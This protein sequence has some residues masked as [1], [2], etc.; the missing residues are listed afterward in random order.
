MLML[1]RH[2]LFLNLC[3][4]LIS[5]FTSIEAFAT[6]EVTQVPT[7]IGNGNWS[8]GLGFRGGTF[9]YKGE[10]KVDDLLPLILYNGEKFFIDGSRLGFHLYQSDDWLIGAYAAYR[11]SGYD[12]EDSIYLKGM[13][14]DDGVDGRFA[15]TRLTPYGNL[16]V[17]LGHDVSSASEGWDASVRWGKTFDHGNYRIRPWIGL[18]YEDQ[19]L[20]N[21]YFGVE[22]YEA[23][24]DRAAYETGSAFEWHYGIDMT[25]RVG[26]HHYFGLNVQYTELDSTKI[27]S[28]IVA[29]SHVISGFASYRYEFND[30]QD[31]L[32]VNGS[33]LKDLQK[34]EWYWRVAAGRHTDTKFNDLMTFKDMFNPEERNTGLASVFV[35]KKIADEFL[36]L[37]LEAY[38]TGG[39]ARRFEKD[40]QSDFNEY[41]LG[42]K[43]YFTK[44]PW[45]DRVKTRLGFAEGISYAESVPFVERE[46]VEEKNR[47]ASKFLNY[48]DW[49]W[50]VSVGDLFSVPELKECYVGWSVHHRSGIFASSDFFGSVDGGSNVNTLYLQCHH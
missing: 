1:K 38:V 12:D 26:Q 10:D 15:L 16:T 39:I 47:S 35:G 49:S 37:P 5:L 3:I 34:G 32:Y 46:S 24:V 9:P 31:N 4:L 30:Y 44:F 27:V 48:L 41:V 40:Y 43:V 11:F 28:P 50:D 7:V 19:K 13:E 33:I 14:R 36:W 29:D 6:R 42:F 45:S 21:Y 17:D 25:Y 22:S 8:L 18:T 2:S 20:T 23:T